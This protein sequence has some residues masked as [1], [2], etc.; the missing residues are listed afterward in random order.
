MLKIN[1]W[2]GYTD[3][4]KQNVPRTGQQ[5]APHLAVIAFTKDDIKKSTAL[6][7]SS[8]KLIDPRYIYIYIYI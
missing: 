4:G 1:L 3:V 8:Y 6:N 5:R 7:F 2:D